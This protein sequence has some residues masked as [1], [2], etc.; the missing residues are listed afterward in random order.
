MIGLDTNVVVRYIVQNNRKQSAK[1]TR[2]FDGLTREQPGFLPRVAFV[3][4]VWVLSSSDG[5]ETR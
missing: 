1:A 2:L 5:L 4:M 3:E